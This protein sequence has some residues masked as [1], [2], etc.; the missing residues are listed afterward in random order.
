MMTKEGL[1][2]LIDAL[3]ESEL[4]EAARLLAALETTDPV[5][6]ALLLAPE[7]DEPET[8]EERA[9]VDEA[10]QAARRGEVFTLEDVEERHTMHLEDYFEFL[11]PDDIRISGT[12]VGIETVLYEYIHRGQ[13]PEQIAERFDALTLE[14]V[15]ATI[16]YYLRNRESVSAYLTAWLEYGERAR[17]VQAKDPAFQ[18][19][20]ERLRQA[21][22][23]RAG[24][25]PIDVAPA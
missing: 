3:P 17:A 5:L 6:R 21:R 25:T 11:A 13:T 24:G 23:A 2:Q 8:D 1:H 12:R 22:V 16:L 7:D 19:L 15:Y 10:R 14:Q 18:R 20:Q 4:D 9:A